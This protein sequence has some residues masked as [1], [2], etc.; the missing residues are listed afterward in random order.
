MKIQSI[1]LGQ[2][3]RG[4]HIQGMRPEAYLIYVDA[5][6]L[7]HANPNTIIGWLYD[8]VLPSLANLSER[9]KAGMNI[10]NEAPPLGIKPFFLILEDR[11]KEV[12]D[13]LNRA[14]EAK[15]WDRASVLLKNAMSTYRWMEGARKTWQQNQ[16]L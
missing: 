15:S 1:E 5:K 10:S 4:T 6:M 11:Y 3:V 14:I 16:S 2:L 12:C 7:S 13:A 8:M 9:D